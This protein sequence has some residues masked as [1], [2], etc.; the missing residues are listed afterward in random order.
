MSQRPTAPPPPAPSP[1]TGGRLI[2]SPASTIPKTVGL[3][4]S[5]GEHV[6]PDRILIYG[7]GGIGKT[8]LA[9]YLP[10][11]LFLDLDRGLRHIKGARDYVSDWQELRG[12]LATIAQ[13]PP[14]G[15]RTVVI[16][17]ITVAEE[18][19]KEY[20]VETRRTDK[21][22]AVDSVEGFGWGKGWQFVYD[23][24]NALI[25]DLDRLTARGLYVCLIA[26]VLTTPCPNPQGEDFLR[27]EP[28]V[29]GGDKKGR[30]NLR[31]RL[32]N[33]SDHTLFVGY[34]VW[35][36]DGKA[37]GNGT[38]TVY[39]TELPTHLA[40]SRSAVDSIPYQ[41]NDPGAIWRALNIS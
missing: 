22:K 30:G 24:F 26:H 29:Y 16:D 15:L 17:T 36:E 34:D 2:K 40:K 23:E 5:H 8:S 32:K 39:A 20:V 38:R 28:A 31:E 13:S 3:N 35:A 25:T 11:P 19:A 4:I 18:L 33:W 12:K 14:Q 6:D 7:T 10:A 1:A 37:R 21:G 9:S 41:L 27:W